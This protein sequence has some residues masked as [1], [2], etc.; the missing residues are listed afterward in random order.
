VVGKC[1]TSPPD[2]V[3][4]LPHVAMFGMDLTKQLD[5]QGG[6]ALPFLVQDCIQA[7]E[8]RGMQVEGIYRKTGPNSHLRII[9]QALADGERPDLL[10]DEIDITA[11]TSCVKL[12]LRELPDPVI[13]FECYPK[14]LDAFDPRRDTCV[15]DVKAVLK[16]NLPKAHYTTLYKLLGHLSRVQSYSTVNLMPASNL[17]VVFGPTLLKHIEPERELLDVNVKNNLVAFLIENVDYLFTA[18]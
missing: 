13:T 4:E 15:A 16:A 6:G 7:V 18:S 2:T 11:V 1:L 12:Y 9:L 8:A 5:V 14:L 3:F 17:A 10:D